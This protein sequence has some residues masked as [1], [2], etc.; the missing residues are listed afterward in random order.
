MAASKRPDYSF[1]SPRLPTDP[2]L[3][4][5]DMPAAQEAWIK[6]AGSNPAVRE[7]DY[8]LVLMYAL[9]C[10]F[11]AR[12]ERKLEQPGLAQGERLLYQQLVK[13][14]QALLQE[15]LEMFFPDGD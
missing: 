6:L 3:E 9:E 11:L 4:L 12:F 15:M 7:L 10:E 2:P 13:G 8:D 14:K 1:G 5:D